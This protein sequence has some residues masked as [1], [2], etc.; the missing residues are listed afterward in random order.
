MLLREHDVN[1][2]TSEDERMRGLL[3]IERDLEL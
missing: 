2:G 3:F 1:D